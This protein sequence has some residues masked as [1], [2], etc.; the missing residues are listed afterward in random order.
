MEHFNKIEI[1]KNRIFPDINNWKFFYVTNGKN[2]FLI[3]KNYTI[4]ES[5]GNFINYMDTFILLTKT[6]KNK[7]EQILI[8]AGNNKPNNEYVPFLWN[9]ILNSLCIKITI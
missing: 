1:I 4:K 5:L 8:I 7:K 6:I 9:R 2:S 3:T